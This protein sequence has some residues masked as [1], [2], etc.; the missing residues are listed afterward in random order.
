MRK[1]PKPN[2]TGILLLSLASIFLIL[3]VL[4][5]AVLSPFLRL[6]Q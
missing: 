4:Y 3:L 2:K 1:P 6:K 5:L